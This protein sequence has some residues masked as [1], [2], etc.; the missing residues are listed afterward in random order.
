MDS[1]RT[2]SASCDLSAIVERWIEQRTS[3]RVYRLH[4]EIAENRLIVY[5]TAGSHYV[6]QL[7]LAAA[8]DALQEMDVMPHQVDLEIHVRERA[9]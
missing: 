3:G 8:L 5:G 1:Q 4:V 9:R 6:R 7:A 2:G